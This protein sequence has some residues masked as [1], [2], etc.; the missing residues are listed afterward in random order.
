LQDV[1]KR[2]LFVAVDGHVVTLDAR[3]FLAVEDAEPHS[4][5]RRDYTAARVGQR[6]MS[7][8]QHRYGVLLLRG[9]RCA[10]A[11]DESGK[12]SIPMAEPSGTESKHQTAKSA[13]RHACRVSVEELA[14]LSDVPPAVAYSASGEKTTAAMG[15][16][17][18]QAAPP[19]LVLTVFA[20]TAT[21]SP[22]EDSGGCCGDCGPVDI[23]DKYDW[24]SFEEALRG[25]S[26]E[27]ERVCL[28]HVISRKTIPVFPTVVAHPTAPSWTAFNFILRKPVSVSFFS[29]ER[30]SSTA[31]SLRFR[32][33]W[34]PLIW[35][36]SVKIV[37]FTTLKNIRDCDK[38]TLPP[39]PTTVVQ[40]IKPS[41]RHLQR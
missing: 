22:P 27:S 23:E 14:F 30:A 19:S 4:G 15:R 41:F 7:H 18:T 16:D 20:A 34:H 1:I 21:S 39:W 24:Y 12:L 33:V 6:N 32:F 37:S 29:K 5:F 36:A 2:G 8:L 9:A 28:F 40:P 35:N 3:L 10:L 38:K 17:A 26:S 13:F 11:K 25:L 31:P